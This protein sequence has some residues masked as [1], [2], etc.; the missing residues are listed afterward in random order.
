MSLCAYPLHCL[1]ETATTWV[2]VLIAINRY[3]IVCL[4]L[5]ASQ[6]CTASRVKTQLAV[7]LV[8]VVLCNIPNYVR[9]R[10]VYFT[11]NNGTTCEVIDKGKLSC[12]QFYV[13]PL[14]YDVFLHFIQF[15]CLPLFILTYLTIRLIKAMRANRRLQAEMQSQNSKHDNNMTFALAI[16]VIVFIICQAPFLIL[17][18]ITYLNRS[19]VVVRCYMSQIHHTLLAFNS[20]VNFFIYIVINKQFRDVLIE[21]VFMRHGERQEVIDNIQDGRQVREGKCEPAD[22]GHT[23]GNIHD[24][25]EG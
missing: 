9:L 3:I 13:D 4:P 6:W 18:V 5:K 16:V 19:S 10:V 21:H 11:Q 17:L 22:D 20:A 23:T 2:T 12:P 24:I 8:F 15:W 7:V 25:R 1:T 14:F